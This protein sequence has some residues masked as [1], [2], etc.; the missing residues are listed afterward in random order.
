MARYDERYFLSDFPSYVAGKEEGFRMLRHMFEL[1][2]SD[3]FITSGDYPT[4]DL[5]GAKKIIV[6]R[7]LSGLEVD[8]LCN[9]LI[10]K[11]A[12]TEISAMVSTRPCGCCSYRSAR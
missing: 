8:N 6:P 1:G 7:Q 11:D 5:N 4:I 12:V 2:A 10:G 9:D 3:L